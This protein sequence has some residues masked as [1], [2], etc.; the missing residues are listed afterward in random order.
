MA[1]C[2]TIELPSGYAMP[3]VGLGTFDNLKDDMICEAV[4]AALDSGYR[5][6]DCAWI[7]RSESAVGA[8]LADRIKA[9]AVTRNELFI[10]TKLWNTF[11]EPD[12]VEAG[13]RD[14]LNDLG[15]DYVD[16]LLM[17]WPMAFKEQTVERKA[18]ILNTQTEPADVDFLDTW[19]AMEEL[20]NKGLARSIGISNFNIQQLTRLLDA[21]GL[22]YKPANIQ[23]ESH[24]FFLNKELIDFCQGRGI[25]V[26]A[27]SPL[28]KGGSTYAG[29]PTENIL[30][31][32]TITSIAKA[33]AHSP[34]QVVLRW[35]LQR[36][37]SIVPKSCT[38]VRI[39][40]NIQLFDFSLTEDEM[41]AISLLDKHKRLVTLENFKGFPE[42]PFKDISGC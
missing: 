11:H 4:K 14:S 25:T 41:A 13:L 17:H 18:W 10:S 7:Y 36:G 33:Q 1:A 28:G 22:R 16:L 15:L 42:Y 3:L 26:T 8:A 23:V 21:P 40:E 12:R 2:P 29:K 31:H 9:G 30:E 24:P 37:L 19:R 6:V 38:P 34:A 20:V 35:A 5:M 39:R 27:Y 32:P